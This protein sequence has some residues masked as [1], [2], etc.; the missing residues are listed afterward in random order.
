MTASAPAAMFSLLMLLQNRARIGQPCRLQC[1]PECSLP[2]CK[3]G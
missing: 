2:E 3:V 1:I